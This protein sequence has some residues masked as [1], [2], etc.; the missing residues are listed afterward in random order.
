MALRIQTPS[1]DGNWLYHDR[2]ENDRYFTKK[3]ILGKNEKEWA[4][5]RDEDKEEWERERQQTY[6]ETPEPEQKGGDV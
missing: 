5:C 4:E 3:V 1:V 2:G 6:P